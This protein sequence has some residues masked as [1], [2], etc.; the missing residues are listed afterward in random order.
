LYNSDNHEL[1][2]PTGSSRPAGTYTN[3]IFNNNSQLT[4][5]GEGGLT[6]PGVVKYKKTFAPMQWYA[7]G[8]PFAL[9][10][11]WSDF[12][13]NPYL[14]IWNNSEG[15][16][17]VKSYDGVNNK[18]E[19]ST[20]MM[21]NTGYI[22]QF[23]NAFTGKEVIFT[24]ETGVTLKNITEGNLDEALA[25]A[26]NGYF[27]VANP[28]V[29]DLELSASAANKYYIYNSSTNNFGLLQSG[30]ATVK[31]FESFV[32]AKGIESSVLRSSL[33]IQEV[34]ALEQLQWNDPVVRTEYYNLQGM[35]VLSPAKNGLY[36][37]K[38]THTSGKTSTIK[39][40][41]PSNK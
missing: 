40:I 10:N 32:V 37:V 28:S 21:A 4:G 24:S 19:Y 35:K 26:D 20:E 7:V 13:D 12:T 16:F 11:S 33:N 17:W 5:I 9:A 25:L 41:Y 36:I 39:R 8:F 15:D 31:P 27:L 18:F 22:I 30:S 23:P 1:V 34:T 14:S 6:I 2:I 29:S 3:I 38:K